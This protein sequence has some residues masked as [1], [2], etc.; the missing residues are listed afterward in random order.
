MR[1]DFLKIFIDLKRSQNIAHTSPRL[2]VNP[3]ILKCKSSFSFLHYCML[4]NKQSNTLIIQ[5]DVSVLFVH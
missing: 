1:N 5:D 2:N 4:Q 3:R